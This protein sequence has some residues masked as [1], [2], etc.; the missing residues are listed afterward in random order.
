VDEG[1]PEVNDASP[2]GSPNPSPRLTVFLSFDFDALSGWVGDSQNPAD[3]SRDEFAAVAVPRVLDLLDRHS[4]RGTLFIP[5]HT[6]LAYPNQ[7]LDI[8][9]RGHEIG[10]HR[11]VHDAA[12]SFDDDMQREIFAKG[13]EALAKVTG[14]RPVGYRS[15]GGSYNSTSID[16]LVE[17]NVLYDSHFS[18]SDFQVVGHGRLHVRHHD[19][20]RRAS[21]RLAHGRLRPL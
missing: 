14:E 4:I 20:P 1:L 9:R 21:V 12:A 7:V 5:G 13:I 18:A 16:I 19:R 11:W 15:P 8:Q 10:H 6:A 17:N 2:A 3:I